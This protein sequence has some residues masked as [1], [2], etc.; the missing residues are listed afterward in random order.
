MLQRRHFFG[1]HIK[2]YTEIFAASGDLKVFP[3]QAVKACKDSS[4]VTP[5]ILNLGTRWKRQT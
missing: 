5:F 3:A 2:I 1:K 4:G